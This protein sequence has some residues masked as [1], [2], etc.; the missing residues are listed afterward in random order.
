MDII[1]LNS[2]T[3]F[4]LN[5]DI[6]WNSN[7]GGFTENH[8]TNMNKLLDDGELR[9]LII[10]LKIMTNEIY[11]KYKEFIVPT[12]GVDTNMR[13]RESD[14]GAINIKFEAL[15]R[16]LEFRPVYYR[17]SLQSTPDSEG[18]HAICI[19][20]QK[21][22]TSYKIWVGNCGMGGWYHNVKMDDSIYSESILEFDS[23]SKK[24][25]EYFVN[26]LF[27]HNTITEFYNVSIPLLLS[28]SLTFDSKKIYKDLMT[29]YKHKDDNY[30][31]MQFIGSCSFKSLLFAT[32][33]FMTNINDIPRKTAENF[34]LVCRLFS[35][36][37]LLEHINSFDAETTK[38][39]LETNNDHYNL[40]KTTFHTFYE[41]YSNKTIDYYTDEDSINL[42]I[43]T[44]LGLEIEIMFKIKSHNYDYDFTT[45]QEIINQ[46]NAEK[47]ID[48]DDPKGAIHTGDFNDFLHEEVKELK[49][50]NEFNKFNYLSE[51][52]ANYRNHFKNYFFKTFVKKEDIFS[53]TMTNI[54]SED[55]KSV[56]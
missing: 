43:D 23:I 16:E 8:A 34:F 19:V 28:K 9:D 21:I 25:L 55:R 29:N 32:H 54:I 12:T 24:K 1:N 27:L 45:N 13:G 51:N 37:K 15:L 53:T 46:L 6:I 7:F 20:F 22:S 39:F 48:A 33:V 56:V 38:R 26:F 18:E 2:K 47:D 35:Y 52:S 11:D 50:V 49:I 30:F 10:G 3:I 4:F 44:I 40:L 36:R 14:L 5:D 17:V 42:L 41:L 31:E